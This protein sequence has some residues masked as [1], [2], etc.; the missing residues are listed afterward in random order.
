MR[1]PLPKTVYFICATFVCGQL[2][3]YTKRDDKHINKGFLRLFGQG[4]VKN[5]AC[6]TPVDLN[7]N[8]VAR[9][10]I[11]VAYVCEILGI[12]GRVCQKLHRQFQECITVGQSTKTK[13]PGLFHHSTTSTKANVPV[14][15]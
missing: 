2:R 13:P 6:A 4:H 11:T 8:L 5:V 7:Q 12:F 9:I 10:S 14:V 1:W 3:I 15:L